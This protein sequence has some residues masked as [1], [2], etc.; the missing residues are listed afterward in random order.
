KHRQV[1]RA[2]RWGEKSIGII[3]RAPNPV[4]LNYFIGPGL[5][6]AQWQI[7]TGLVRFIQHR[8]LMQS[9]ALKAGRIRRRVF[10]QLSDM[11]HGGTATR[12]ESIDVEANS[13]IIC[14][15]VAPR[16]MGRLGGA[17]QAHS[18]AWVPLS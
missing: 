11:L 2:R 15:V 4:A 17:K 9:E 10:H 5:P 13:L 7:V 14:V 16:D 12:P 3:V 1:Q 8:P 18:D 6:Q